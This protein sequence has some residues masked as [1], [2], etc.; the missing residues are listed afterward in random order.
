MSI[1]LSDLKKSY[2]SPDGGVTEVLRIR[3]FVVETGREVVITGKSGSGKTTLLNIIGGIVIP[4]SGSVLVEG[5]EVTALDEAARDRFRASRIGYVFQTFNLLPAFTTLENVLLAMLF[6]GRVDRKRAEALLA[7]VGLSDR[8]SY[9]PTALSVG[10]Q[11]RVA[12]AR[13]LANRPALILADE[14]TGNVDPAAGA[15]IVDLLKEVCLE[16]GVTL[17]LVTHQPDV[18]RR[19]DQVV[20]LASLIEA[21]A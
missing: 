11:Q 7:R 15:G 10:Q 6:A 19:F 8:L 12:I 20:D 13:A 14:P 2:T 5:T 21:A 16:D 4:D 18:V 17:I 9:P 3:R 1:V